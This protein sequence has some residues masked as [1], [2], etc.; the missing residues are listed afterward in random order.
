VVPTGNADRPGNKRS[1]APEQSS[2]QER[3]SGEGTGNQIQGPGEEGRRRRSNARYV[4]WGD[5]LD[6]EYCDRMSH[7]LPRTFPVAT[8]SGAATIRPTVVARRADTYLLCTYD[9]CGPHMWPD[10]GIVSDDEAK[11]VSQARA[12]S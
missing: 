5:G 7:C 4:G 12:Q 6:R 8:H 2:H 10:G 3:G 11:H 9:H 1:N